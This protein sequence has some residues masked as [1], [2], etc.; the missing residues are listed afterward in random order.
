MQTHAHAHPIFRV[1]VL[2]VEVDDLADE[3]NR[4]ASKFKRIL[5]EMADSR[6]ALE[7]ASI[8]IGGAS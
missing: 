6:R 2:A 5:D 7:A 4:V 3:I 1:A 8:E